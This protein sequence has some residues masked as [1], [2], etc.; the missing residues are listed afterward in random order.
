MKEKVLMEKVEWGKNDPRV[1]EKEAVQ[2]C[3]CH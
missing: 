1:L 2:N 3:D